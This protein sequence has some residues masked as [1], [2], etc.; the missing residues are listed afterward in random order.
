M[1]I[2]LNTFPADKTLGYL[3][4]GKWLTFGHIRKCR[5]I[6]QIGHEV[7]R[8]EENAA[9]FAHGFLGTTLITGHRNTVN[10][11]QN[12]V[13]MPDDFA[14][15]NFFGILGQ[16]ISAANAGA[17][18]DP[19]LGFEGEHDLLEKSLG[20]VVPPGQFANGDRLTAIMVHQGEHGAQG[21]VRFL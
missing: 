16:E 13:E 18:I 1:K 17:A 12:A 2:F 5:L 14:H 8:I 19:A 10:W 21:V 15:R 11:G 9:E 20:N 4:L 6:H 3:V 7:T